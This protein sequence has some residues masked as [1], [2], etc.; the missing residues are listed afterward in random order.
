MTREEFEKRYK[1]EQLWK[2]EKNVIIGK[3]FVY[4]N[5]NEIGVTK[6]AEDSKYYTFSSSSPEVPGPGYIPPEQEYVEYTNKKGVH[7]KIPLPL[8]IGC[9]EYET[10]EEALD[11]LYKEIKYL[12]HM[13]TMTPEEKEEE[14]KKW[15][16]EYWS[17]PELYEK[18]DEEEDK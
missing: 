14:Y 11:D 18:K 10:E 2:C 15:E 9:Q 4:R 6:A 1:E 16:I 13:N 12:A 5:G 3:G 17:N 8:N 7:R